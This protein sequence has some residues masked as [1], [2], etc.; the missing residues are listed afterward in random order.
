MNCIL[1]TMLCKFL[2]D[3]FAALSVRR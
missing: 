2:Y 1:G 3:S